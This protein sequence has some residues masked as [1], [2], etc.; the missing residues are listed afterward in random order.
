MSDQIIDNILKNGRQHP[1]MPAII[2]TCGKNTIALST[3]LG[4]FKHRQFV[5][6]FYYLIN[7][8]YKINSNLFVLGDYARIVDFVPQDTF[9]FVFIKDNVK[10]RYDEVAHLLR[11]I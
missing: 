11:V 9:M 2:Y 7:R 6:A 10:T 8:G 4:T 1:S 5:T 3:I